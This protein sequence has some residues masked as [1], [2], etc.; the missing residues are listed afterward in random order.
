M[1]GPLNHLLH[2]FIITLVL[3][4]IMKPNN[5]DKVYPR[6][7]SEYKK[8]DSLDFQR[9]MGNVYKKRP[10]GY[11]IQGLLW[12]ACLIIGVSM[13]TV[14]FLLDISVEYIMEVRWLLV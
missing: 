4:L 14:A 9:T 1:E 6:K 13:G 3:Y 12:L 11:A 7:D 10:T 8:K 2:A 5:S